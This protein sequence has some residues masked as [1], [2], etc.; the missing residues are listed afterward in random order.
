MISK[1]QSSSRVQ[2]TSCEAA[3]REAPRACLQRPASS[4]RREHGASAQP[5]SPQAREPPSPSGSRTSTQAAHAATPA[6][7]QYL[8]SPLIQACQSWQELLELY[9]NNRTSMLPGQLVL[10]LSCLAKTSSGS[11]SNMLPVSALSHLSALQQQVLGLAGQ[12][13]LQP[14]ELAT[15]IWASAKLQHVP[16]K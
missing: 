2:R 6:S 13:A 7:A 10:V 4:S 1:P 5:S 9:R 11:R 3:T 15:A 14:R 12:Q 8:F 16:S